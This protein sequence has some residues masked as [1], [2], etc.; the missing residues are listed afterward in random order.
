[1]S[2]S[3]RPIQ[4]DITDAHN[5]SVIY[6][7][8]SAGTVLRDDDVTSCESVLHSDVDWTYNVSVSVDQ[9]PSA[10]NTVH[11]QLN[12]SRQQTLTLTSRTHNTLPGIMVAL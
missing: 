7:N 8:T 9:P 12:V 3:A 1:M 4:V 10:I 11:R 5:S 2:V 6:D